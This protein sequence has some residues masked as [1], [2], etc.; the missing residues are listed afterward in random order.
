M[1]FGVEDCSENGVENV[2]FEER[3]GRVS[4]FDKSFLDAPLHH[5]K[6]LCPSVRPSLGPSVPG[7]FR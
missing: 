5:Y 6:R 2:G 4:Q 3:L 1:L 7:F